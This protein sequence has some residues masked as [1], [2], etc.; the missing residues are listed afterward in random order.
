MRG[1]GGPASP[2]TYTPVAELA[3]RACAGRRVGRL[4]PAKSLRD[5]TPATVWI[6]NLLSGAD[7]ELR[8]PKGA[9]APRRIGWYPSGASIVVET[10]RGLYLLNAPPAKA[11]AR[12]VS[13]GERARAES[14]L[15]VLLGDPVFAQVVPVSHPMSCVW[16]ATP[17][18]RA[19]WSAARTIRFAG[20]PTRWLFC[21]GTGSR[22]GR[23]RGGVLADSPG[24]VCRR[25]RGR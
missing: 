1:D 3:R 18:R 15:A 21:W 19:S 23:W 7:R 10:G 22:S 2:L 5:S 12:P 20:D 8:L 24:P 13:A 6:L 25:I 4:S 14:S 9:G 17:E 16:W 11:E